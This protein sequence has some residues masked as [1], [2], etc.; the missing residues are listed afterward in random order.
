MLLNDTRLSPPRDSLVWAFNFA[1]AGAV[2]GGR[3][4]PMGPD[5]ILQ[6]AQFAVVIVDSDSGEYLMTLQGWQRVGAT[7][8]PAVSPSA[9]PEVPSL[10]S[11]G[12]PA[13]PAPAAAP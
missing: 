9:S 8:Q 2:L 3:Y 1:D 7:P 11:Y 10:P 4:Q 5:G 13:T 6:E 12:V